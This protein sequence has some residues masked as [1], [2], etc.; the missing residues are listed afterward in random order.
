MEMAIY[1]SG[2]AH[3]AFK[4]R[5]AEAGYPKRL[6]CNAD[7]RKTVR[8]RSQL[9][10]FGL[11]LVDIAFGPDLQ[12]GERHGSARGLVAIGDQAR[13]GIAVGGAAFGL[14]AVG[15]SAVGVVAVGG[16]C[17][18]VFAVGG[19]ALGAVALGGLS[20]GVVA[21]GGLSFARSV[22]FWPSNV[23]ILPRLL[24]QR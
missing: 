18:G 9:M 21:R 17:L 8:K 11:P 22:A 13:G 6:R 5:G 1:D 19:L 14:I 3:P 12:T 4:A 24:G 23:W 20:V 15:G 2:P 16:A 10:I 7:M